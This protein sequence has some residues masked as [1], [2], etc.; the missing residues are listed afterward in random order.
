MS[1]DMI[2]WGSAF[3]A[4]LLISTDPDDN[5]LRVAVMLGSEIIHE[6]PFTENEAAEWRSM[7]DPDATKALLNSFVA[8]RLRGFLTGGRTG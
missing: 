5:T 3:A 1:D 8:K 7:T 2:R 6:W 4:A